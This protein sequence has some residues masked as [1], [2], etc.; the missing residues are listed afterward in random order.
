M[1]FTHPSRRMVVSTA[2][3]LALA[4][5]ATAG[6]AVASSHHEVTVEVDGVS[7][8]LEG[9][10]TT[11]DDVL[12][13]AG[14]QV[15]PHDLIAP[16]GST[17]VSD[18]ETIVVRTATSYD[19]TVNGRAL[20]AWS[21]ADSVD[22]VLDGVGQDGSIVLAADRSTLRAEMPVISEATA[23]NVLVD[24]TTIAVDAAVGDTADAL[25]KKAGVALG[26]L[27]TV[28]FVA[29]KGT[30]S[31]KVTRVVRGTV[32]ETSALPYS[33]E[34][35]ED[36]SLYVGD[37]EVLQEGRDGSTTTT[38]FR[39]TVDGRITV[40][41]QVGKTVTDPVTK[42]VAVGTKEKPVATTT[43]TASSSSSSSSSASASANLSG[44]WAALAQCESGGNPTTNTGNGYYGLYQFSLSTWRS[45]G[46]TGLPSEASAAE[47]TALAQA[48]QARSGWG[49][50]PA[51]A[52]ALGLL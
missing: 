45:L 32:D 41:V 7:R 4:M 22:G 13:S 50:W 25:L 21:T 2:S 20:T 26:D 42:I 3:A 31:L 5:T 28:D 35:R 12:A 10:F 15:G 40:N 18:G 36:D 37:T 51:C 47:Q 6:T 17:S 39:E 49:Q 23:V 43:S 44:V 30:T 52:A 34:E 46:G 38:Y 48:L 8:P 14:I 16:E 29:E 27:D 33:T 1:K 11:V 19:V 9:F 24:G